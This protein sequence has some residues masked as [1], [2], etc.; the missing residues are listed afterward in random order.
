M[1]TLTDDVLF[2]LGILVLDFLAEQCRRELG[3][4]AAMDSRRRAALP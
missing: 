1:P 3:R 2:G 4:L